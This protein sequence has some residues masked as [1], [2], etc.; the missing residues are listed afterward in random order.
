M[1]KKKKKQKVSLRPIKRAKRRNSKHKLKLIVE[2]FSC[3][4]VRRHTICNSLNILPARWKLL[5]TY[6]ADF[7]KGRNNYQSFDFVVDEIRRREFGTLRS[8]LQGW[9]DSRKSISNATLFSEARKCMVR[10]SLLWL[11][12]HW[13]PAQRI[14]WFNST[15]L[16][17]RKRPTQ[18][19]RKLFEWVETEIKQNE[20]ILVTDV[21]EKAAI[22]VDASF[23]KYKKFQKVGQW[24]KN[25]LSLK[26]EGTKGKQKKWVPK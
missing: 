16:Y 17:G 14:K 21:R 3:D 1:E 5:W 18:K 6:K 22:L 23:G 20:D 12:H 11:K 2:S 10:G 13:D 25:L 8:S 9:V 26:S 15:L 7:I 19:F 4:E 24:I